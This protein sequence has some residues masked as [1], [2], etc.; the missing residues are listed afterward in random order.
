[1]PDFSKERH[2][3]VARWKVGDCHEFVHVHVASN[4]NYNC[5]KLWI[6]YDE[7]RV[8]IDHNKGNVPWGTLT[9]I[10]ED[11]IGSMSK[12]LKRWEEAVSPEEYVFIP[13]LREDPRFSDIARLE[14]HIGLNMEHSLSSNE[15][16]N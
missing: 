12:L 9:D 11:V 4:E 15:P 2:G 3:Y 6:S 5:A 8:L 13:I 1:M 10:I 14:W 7:K 16:P